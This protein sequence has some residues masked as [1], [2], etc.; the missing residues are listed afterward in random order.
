MN[1][2]IWEQLVY[3]FL[4]NDALSNMQNWW[5][6]LTASS[7]L[8]FFFYMMLNFCIILAVFRLVEHIADILLNGRWLR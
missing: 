3:I 4:N 1:Q 6:L 2:P 8:C 7:F 5:T